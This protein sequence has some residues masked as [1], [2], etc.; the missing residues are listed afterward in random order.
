MSDSRY[1][2]TDHTHMQNH[3]VKSG[4]EFSWDSPFNCDTYDI[5]SDTYMIPLVVIKS[6]LDIMNQHPPGVVP[7]A[8]DGISDTYDPILEWNRLSEQEKFDQDTNLLM[9]ILPEMLVLARWVQNYPVHDEFIRG[10]QELDRNREIPMYLVFAVQ[11]FLDINHI[12]RGQV[13][14]GQETCMS[15]LRFMDEDLELHMEFHAKFR[16]DKRT[17]AERQVLSEV[18]KKIKV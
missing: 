15:H 10:M 12:L 9:E 13:Y 8:K 4:N 2:L 5:A 11:I 6:F 17:A 16:P 14:S 18:R 3:I 7:I 1:P